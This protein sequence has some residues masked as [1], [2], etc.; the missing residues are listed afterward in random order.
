MVIEYIIYFCV[1]AFSVISRAIPIVLLKN[2][3][4]LSDEYYYYEMADCLKDNKYHF[5]AKHPRLKP[6]V[7]FHLPAAYYY[8]LALIPSNYR[9]KFGGVISAVSD[10]MQAVILCVVLRHLLGAD[11]ANTLYM[12]IVYSISAPL[13]L[14][15]S[16]PRTFE[17]TPRTVGELLAQ[18]A[19]LSIVL[20][21]SGYG[22][23][24]YIIGS[25]LASIA[26]NTSKFAAQA[27]LF[28]II[29]I[30][31]IT[32]E[33]LILINP[34][35][36]FLTAVIISNGYYINV[37]KAQF[38]HLVQ[39][40]KCAKMTGS[41]L[42][43]NNLGEVYKSIRARQVGRA[44]ALLIYRCDY[45]QYVIKYNQVIIVLAVAFYAGK[46][47]GNSFLV[48]MAIWVLVGNIIFALI[49]FGTLA[50]LGEA[51][52]Y[53]QY[54]VMPT[55]IMLYYYSRYFTWIWQYYLVSSIIAYCIGVSLYYLNCRRYVNRGTLWSWLRMQADK[56]VA[57]WVGDMA[58]WE[59]IYKV[60]NRSW[61]V[62][63]SWS[64]SISN[65]EIDS[66][67]LQYPLVRECFEYFRNRYGVE[68]IVMDRQAVTKYEKRYCVSYDTSKY[69]RLY[70]DQIHEVYVMS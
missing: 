45:V 2:N 52:R 18:C 59:A 34:I 19:V 30:G 23:I 17:A 8:I 16:G 47:I 14:S 67:Y 55:A 37:L 22:V 24:Y 10:G 56:R 38:R 7:S 9:E 12:G 21:M 11:L 60:K 25:V 20:Y 6:D 62:L 31:I 49:S 43:R 65:S 46:I 53:L 54:I 3:S 48:N 51:E 68:I 36:V 61:V 29:I 70:Q 44:V 28:I 58:P 42:Y 64:K 15:L 26:V 5:Q 63:D 39:Y 69:K 33:T 4:S 13:V 50:F 40:S 32:Q 1:F 35:I 27:Y 57:L 66:Y 41:I